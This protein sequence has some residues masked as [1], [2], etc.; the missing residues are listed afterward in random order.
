MERPDKQPEWL[1]DE[2]WDDGLRYTEEWVAPKRSFPS[3]RCALWAGDGDEPASTLVLLGMQVR[4]G[5]LAV[6][7]EGYA[8]VNTAPEQRRRGYMERLFRRSLRSAGARVSVVCLYGIADFYPR[9]GFVTCQR[10]AEWRVSLYDTRR[11]PAVTEGTLRTGTLSDL[12]AMRALYNDVHGRRPWTVARADD[13]DRLPRARPWRP[14][15]E[16]CLAARGDALTGYA[17]IREEAFGWRRDHLQLDEVVA[18]DLDTARLLLAEAARRA[19]Q[20]DYERIVFHEPSDSA[21]AHAAR[22]IGCEVVYRHYAAGGGMAALLDRARFLDELRP[23]LARRAAAARV[24]EA[25]QLPALA[26]LRGGVLLPGDGDL[27][28][29]AF[30]YERFDQVPE[31]RRGSDPGL[32]EV[33]QAWFPGGGTRVLEEPFAHLLDDY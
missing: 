31:E 28:Q 15:A 6:P 24:S 10:G 30:G 18:R 29:L 25:A 33:A 5:A 23:E 16:I 19:R 27:L 21:V 14:G 4:F 32:W 26:A 8:A 2:A 3:R 7:V 1:V 22:A 9:Y 11:L 12:P 17:V 20:L 13:W